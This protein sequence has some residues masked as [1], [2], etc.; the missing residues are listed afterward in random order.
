[1]SILLALH[2]IVT[3]LLIMIILIQK[4][5]GGSSLFASSGSGSLLS[6]RGASNLLTKATWALATIFLVNCV[7]MAVIASKDIKGRNTIIEHQS[8]TS[9][10]SNQVDPNADESESDEGYEDGKGVPEFSRH[11]DGTEQEGSAKDE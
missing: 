11:G 6:A 5:D 10:S 7:V 2:I 9:E 4:N 3:A 8:N 1:M